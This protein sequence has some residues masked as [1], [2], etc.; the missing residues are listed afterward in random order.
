MDNKQLFSVLHSKLFLYDISAICDY[1]KSSPHC[2]EEVAH[3]IRVADEVCEHSFLFD[4]RWDMERTYEPEI[5]EGD[6]D[7]LTPPGDDFEWVFAFNRHRFWICL[8]QAYAL[9]GDE[10]YAKEF[11]EQLCHW[12]KNV[13]RTNENSAA[14]RTIEAGLRMEYWIKAISYFNGSPHITDEVCK[15]FL[16]SVKEH[17]DYMIEVYDTFRLVSNWGV[18]Q[19]HGLFIA[20]VLLQNDT[21]INTA[22]ERLTEEITIQVY[23]DGVHWEQSPMYHNEVLHCFL[24]VKILCEKNGIAIPAIIDEKLLK[25][26]YASMYHKKPNHMELAMGDSDDI[27]VRDLISK[28]V[29]ALSGVIL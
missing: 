24:D 12:V 27:D 9:T 16:D 25:M 20:G 7:W 26:C 13:P 21:Y 15:V 19:H 14:W 23:S 3:I 4:L 10:R 8:G 22:L 6:I 28:G 2:D 18:L 29:S 11:A 1:I 5:F 17:A